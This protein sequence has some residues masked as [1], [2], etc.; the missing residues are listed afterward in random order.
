MHFTTKQEVN[1]SNFAWDCDRIKRTSYCT[2][3]INGFL[4]KRKSWRGLFVAL[5]LYT[6]SYSYRKD[7]MLAHFFYLLLP[8]KSSLTASKELTA[9]KPGCEH[10][11]SHNVR[12]TNKLLITFPA[13]CTLSGC[14]FS[15]FFFVYLVGWVY[16][17]PCN[18]T[19]RQQF[20]F[21]SIFTEAVK[22]LLL[23]TAATQYERGEL[24]CVINL[25]QSQ[26]NCYKHYRVGVGIV[27]SQCFS[28]IKIGNRDQTTLC[29]K[30]RV[31]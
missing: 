26:S 10:Q 5:A 30:P 27:T 1:G 31:E 6:F 16:C 8:G 29:N 12:R 21:Y 3:M 2:F 22:E 25:I 23:V 24:I 28:P 18:C 19:D 9:S 13:V 11:V 7:E 4:I 17:C 14:I 15:V 20:C